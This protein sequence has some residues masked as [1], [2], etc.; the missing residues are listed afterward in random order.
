MLTLPFTRSLV[1]DHLSMRCTQTAANTTS[2]LAYFY[3]S[4]N[5]APRKQAASL[6]ATIIKQLAVSLGNNLPAYGDD[7]TN[8][9]LPNSL[10]EAYR[11]HKQHG[12]STEHL[13]LAELQNI[14]FK[15][16]LPTPGLGDVYI[17]IDAMD[18]MEERER[19]E[20]YPVLQRLVAFGSKGEAAC[21]VKLFI[22]SRGGQ[23]DLKL[24]FG[25]AG[26]KQMG[27]EQVDTCGDIRKYV[28]SQ[29]T[30]VI[31]A[32]E[33]LGGDVDDGLREKIVESLVK[34]AEG[35]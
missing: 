8:I 28:E 34:G 4:Y 11:N 3:C 25:K 17:A 26:W 19:K 1:I 10:I 24:A 2:L 12:F 14:L 18:E 7:P 22:T 9:G 30:A 29:T 31:E 6:L 15:E 35:M 27:L 13:D 21:K 20:I 16:I 32:G 33:L 23:R 5:E